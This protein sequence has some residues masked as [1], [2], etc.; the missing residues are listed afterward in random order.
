MVGSLPSRPVF[1][2]VHCRGLSPAIP[3]QARVSLSPTAPSPLARLARRADRGPLPLPS[4]FI[5]AK[6]YRPTCHNT[7]N[8]QRHRSR[9]PR[10]L[11]SP[12]SRFK[13]L[14]FLSSSHSDLR[15]SSNH[16]LG[17]F[18]ELGNGKSV[19]RYVNRPN[20]VKL[21]IL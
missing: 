5:R 8:W 14:S 2:S 16:Y 4:T 9:Y 12:T 1:S 20:V 3:R 11:P 10:N 6:Y 15:G 21:K 7:E 18:L 17:R 13:A 19:N